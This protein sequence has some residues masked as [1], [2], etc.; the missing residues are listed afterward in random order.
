[1]NEHANPVKVPPLKIQG[2]KTKLVS[3]ILNQ[4]KW[5]GRGRRK[6]N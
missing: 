2:N 3:F 6:F 4:V 1:M 5:D